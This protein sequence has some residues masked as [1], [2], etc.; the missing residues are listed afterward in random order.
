MAM[1]AVRWLFPVALFLPLAGH[2]EGRERLTLT[3][4][5]G[6]LGTRLPH[7][8]E[9]GALRLRRWHCDVDG[10]ADGVCTFGRR[11]R[12]CFGC[13]G[14]RIRCRDRV[15][16][17]VGEQRQVGPV[18]LSCNASVPRTPCGFGRSCDSA[19]EICVSRG[20]VGPAVIFACEPVPAGCELIHSCACAGASLCQAPFDTC[21]DEGPPNS[22][23]CGCGACQ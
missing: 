19:S 9:S 15:L 6:V 10:Q 12:R 8:G 20:P 5:D 11:C 7:P 1:R 21:R 14:I 18:T 2:V 23:F 3:C 17:P 16:V 4:V 22:I 13:S